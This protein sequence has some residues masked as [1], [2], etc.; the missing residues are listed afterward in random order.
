MS[1]SKASRRIL[2]SENSVL[3]A[4]LLNRN[5]RAW[6]HDYNVQR[7]TDGEFVR[8]YKELRNHSDKFY[9]YLRMS[10]E[11]FDLLFF[12]VQKFLHHV[13]TN[14]RETIS[15]EQRL[16][17]TC[18]YL[19]SGESFSSLALRFKMGK[20]TIAEIVHDTCR[21]IWDILKDD[22]LPA[23]KKEMWLSVAENFEKKWNFP[24]CFG[25]IDGK[26][27]R[28]KCPA[29]S[30]S[31]YHCYKQ[32]FSI[33]LQAVVDADGRLI[34]VDI[35]TPGRQSDGGNFRS[36]NLFRLLEAGELNVP[37]C[38]PLPSTNTTVPF[39]LLGDEGYPLLS[40]LMRPYPQRD[41]DDRKRVFNYRLSRARNSV[42]C[43]FGI[44]A[45][46]W[47]LLNKAIESNVSN[48]VQI[49]KAICILHNFVLTHE[50]DVYEKMYAAVSLTFSL[51]IT[52][53]P[54]QH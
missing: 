25:C 52:D 16:V 9:N 6:I 3:K 23:P 44:M 39:V 46:K 47:R 8:V 50:R 36:S 51:C 41:L 19:A 11:L 35:G 1:L 20:T 12:K 24:N 22:Y 21:V 2:L 29:N 26:H 49:V 45:A 37:E 28:I 5:H 42:E 7:T 13:T 4:K 32:F 48:A 54:Q 33:L 40:Y 31:Q 10:K 17:I 30:G 53:S 34:A 15:A 14:F 38:R 27:V 43:T 18:R